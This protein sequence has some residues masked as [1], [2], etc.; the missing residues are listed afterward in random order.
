M[1]RAAYRFFDAAFVLEGDTP[2]FLAEFDRTYGRFRSDAASGAPHYRLILA[3]DP[4]LVLDGETMRAASAEALRFYACSAILNAVLARVRS[5]Y[6]LHAAALA[7]PAGGGVLLV[8]Q[9]GL[10]KTTLTLALLARRYRFLSDDVAALG[11]ADGLLHP[12]PRALGLRLPGSAPGHKQAVPVEDPAGPVPPRCLFVLADPAPDAPDR[13]PWYAV[14]D[15]L[16]GGLLEGLRSL[17]AVRA[18]E[19]ARPEPYPALRLEL[20]AAPDGAERQV[21]AACRRHDVLLFDWVRGR[22]APPDFGR[23]PRLEPLPASKAAH[24][25][26]HH[27]KGGPDSALVRQEFGGSASRLY[28]ALAGAAAGMACY[29][30]AVGRLEPM[31]DLIEN[32]SRTKDLV[33]PWS[34]P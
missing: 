33:S 5:H 32:V 6:L 2:D 31:L 1:R 29:R 21:L 24:E 11:R 28:L 23:E 17:P 16:P 10:G 18:V 8:G 3:G 14:V 19:V 22:E 9:A 15:R 20:Q 25:M 7:S 13:Q 34:N 4:H 30:L 12:F 26:L 27:L